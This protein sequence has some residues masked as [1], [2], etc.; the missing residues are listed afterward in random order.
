MPQGERRS[1]AK[2]C[3]FASLGLP[4]ED[5]E[6]FMHTNVPVTKLTG[7]GVQG[8]IPPGP[9]RAKMAHPGPRRGRG[10]FS[11]RREE[12]GKVTTEA[13]LSN[14]GGER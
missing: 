5:A 10:I 4:I 14:R 6:V 9:Y 3:R 13:G 1:V 12:A 7:A 8:H 11:L 2:A